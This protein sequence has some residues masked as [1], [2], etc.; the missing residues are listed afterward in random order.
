VGETD[1]KAAVAER[2][3]K[4]KKRKENY[5]QSNHLARIKHIFCLK[6]NTGL[7]TR[8]VTPELKLRLKFY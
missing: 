1:Q 3:K 7:D 6:N 2:Q 5:P 4:K 8:G